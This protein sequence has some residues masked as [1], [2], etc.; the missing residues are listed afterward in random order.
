MMS[1][2][3]IPKT[4]SDYT[5]NMR[6]STRATAGQSPAR[7][8]QGDGWGQGA[9]QAWTDETEPSLSTVPTVSIG[10][11]KE[12]KIGETNVTGGATGQSISSDG[13]NWVAGGVGHGTL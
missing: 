2:R 4:T 6:R 13:T 11:P 12:K 9:N 3:I 8:G 5:Q 10:R 7:L 1:Q